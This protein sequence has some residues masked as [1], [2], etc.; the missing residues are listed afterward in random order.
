MVIMQISILYTYIYFDIE[1]DDA[2]ALCFY[3]AQ[4]ERDFIQNVFFEF[5]FLKQIQKYK[6]NLFICGRKAN[7]CMCLRSDVS[8][9]LLQKCS[10]SVTH[11]F[12]F[13]L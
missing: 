2:K 9:Y 11:M 5:G 8:S 4:R 7:V 1:S 10:M 3:V 6:Q 12:I 13:Y